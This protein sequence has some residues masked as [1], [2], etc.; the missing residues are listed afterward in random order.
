MNFECVSTCVLLVLNFPQGPIIQ[1]N[2]KSKCSS[3]VKL[4]FTVKDRT[5]SNCVLT[6]TKLRDREQLKDFYNILPMT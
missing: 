2:A 4:G 6:S 5:P 3:G 1:R